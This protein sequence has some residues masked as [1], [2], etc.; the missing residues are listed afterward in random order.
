MPHRLHLLEYLRDAALFVDQEG[1]PLNAH[2]L[3]PEHAFLLPDAIRFGDAV[4]DVTQ[5]CVREPVLCL[6]LR[7]LRR[8]VRRDAEHHSVFAGE[9]LVCVAKLARLERSAGGIGFGI[10]EQYDVLAAQ[11]AEIEFLAGISLQMDGGRWIAGFQHVHSVQRQFSHETDIK[12][13]IV[14]AAEL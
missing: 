11:A 14:A 4:V 9:L 1:C 13:T 7:L 5:E 8:R 12:L 6:E 3:F 2:I 10:E